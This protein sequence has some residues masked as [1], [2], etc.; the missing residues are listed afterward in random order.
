MS[1]KSRKRNKKILAVL[2]LAAA[3]T[4][5][6]RRK[7]ANATETKNPVGGVDQIAADSKKSVDKG[8]V[9]TPTT[10]QDN[11][12]AKRSNVSIAKRS[13]RGYG[14]Y[15]VKTAPTRVNGVQ[16]KGRLNAQPITPFNPAQG[17]SQK[18]MKETLSGG[19]TR[20]YAGT[21]NYRKDGG[22]TT[23][24]SGGAAKRGISPILLKGKR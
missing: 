18:T 16:I 15:G 19:D 8:S 12:P 9:K 11:K 23:Y 22:R 13:S 3:A 7:L 21:V 5:A 4:A 1:K 2:G 20:G 6:S 10:I 24:K 17:N 14:D